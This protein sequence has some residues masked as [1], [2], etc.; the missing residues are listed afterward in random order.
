MSDIW[1]GLKRLAGRAPGLAAALRPVTHA[2]IAVATRDNVTW[3]RHKL[4]MDTRSKAEREHD[5]AAARAEAQARAYSEALAAAA[6]EAEGADA[7]LAEAAA[8]PAAPGI[9]ARATG[10]NV[11]MLVVSDLRVDPRVEREARALAAAGYRVTVLCPDPTVGRDPNVRVDWGPGVDPRFIDWRAAQYVGQQPGY[12]GGLFF[13]IALGVAHDLAPFAIHAHD[14]N[15]GFVAYA[16]ARRT[17]A[18]LVVDFHEWTSENVHWDSETNSWLTF[19]DEWKQDL[20]GLEHRLVLEA[21]ASITVSEH[22]A[23][24]ISEEVGGRRTLSLIRNVPSLA[25]EPTRP[26]PPL[27]RQLGLDDERFVLLYQ[28]GTGPTR[29]IEPIIEALAHV[30]GCTLVIRGPSLEYFGEGYREI[31]RQGGYE[32]RLIL[33][34]PVR[35]QDVVAAARGADAGIYSV[36]G[37]GKNFVYALPNKIFEYAAAGLP[38]LAADYPEASKFVRE[39]GIGLT[40]D[41]QD[42]LAIAA[43]IRRLMEEAGLASGLRAS[44]E[45]LTETLLEHDE[46][47]KLVRLY[48]ELPKAAFHG[49]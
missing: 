1:S 8:D 49:R 39:H 11:L 43:A 23:R 24:T 48:Q 44:V 27:K 17:G 33:L 26:Y 30:P 31:A 7:R 4:G 45:R 15:S 25:L 38:V 47:S 28:G 34:P 37:V 21:S 20:K 19:P 12:R 41:P 13:D 42:P 16:L 36:L 6:R 2:V 3:A 5:E 32:D 29:L 46:W 35:S 9:G 10:R 14:L 40:F 18:H 22:I